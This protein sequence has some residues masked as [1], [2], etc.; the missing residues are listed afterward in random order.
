MTVASF[1]VILNANAGTA[2]AKGVTADALGALFELHGLQATIDA[3]SDVSLELRINDAM[4]S[5]AA[6]IVAAGGDG[7]ITALAAK[8]VDT[9]KSLAILP[10]GTVNALAKDLS[11]PL[12]LPAAVAAL[13]TGQSHR[14]DVGEVNGR[15][16][17]HKVVVGLIPGVAAGREHIRGRQGTAAKIGLLRYFFRRLARAKR[18]PVVIDPIDG[19]RRIERVQAIAVA[20]NAYDEGLGQF[21]SRH[22]L[23]RGTLTLYVLRHF[24][25]RDVLRLTTGMLL[26]NWRNDEALS[27][28][29]VRAVTI[30]MRKDLIKVMFDGEV[31]TMQTPLEFTIRPKALSVIVPA[32]TAASAVAA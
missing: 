24:T 15:V 9:D 10:L 5:G 20:S 22:S 26:G 14:I 23:D 27:V 2:S 4:A 6:T 3:R 31:E 1:Y 7:T 30:D 8:L 17:L 32:A 19:L 28:E 11:V 12:D 13:A 21:F 16:F 18:I 25:L 29:S